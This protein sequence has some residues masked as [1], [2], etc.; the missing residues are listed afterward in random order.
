MKLAIYCLT[1]IGV[2][3][4]LRYIAWPIVEAII[5]GWTYA[6]LHLLNPRLR[7]ALREP[8]T[9]WWYIWC[10]WRSAWSRLCGSDA[11]ITSIGIGEYDY[12]P[13]FRVTRRIS[14]LT[15]GVVY[16]EN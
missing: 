15:T 11:Y 7:K 9:L 3:W 4:V 1:A 14:T 12:R 6:A 13:P 8:R 2:A 5:Y 10:P 16:D